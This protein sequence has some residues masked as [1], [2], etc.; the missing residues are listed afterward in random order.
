[1][2]IHT[3]YGDD[4]VMVVYMVIVHGYVIVNNHPDIV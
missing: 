4:S 2:N 1:M 3:M